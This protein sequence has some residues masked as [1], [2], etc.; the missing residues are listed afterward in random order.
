MP[1]EPGGDEAMIEERDIIVAMRDGTRLAVDVYRPDQPGKYPVLYAAALHNKDLQGPDIA[2]IL[3]PQP[4]HAPLWFG[5][6]EAGDT[7]RFIANGYVHVIAQPRGSAKSEGHYGHEDT[8]HYDLIEWITQQPWSNGKVGMVGISGY[9][10]E[11]WRAAAQ[12]HPALKAIFPYDACSAY[13]G[14]F[15]FRDFNPGGVLHTFPY[16]LDVFSTVHESRDRPAELPPPEEE[17]WRRAMQNPDFKQYINLYNILTQKGQR[18]FIMY[19]MMTHPWEFDGTVE[20]A[21]ETFKKIRIPFYTGSGAYAYTYKLHW[22]GAQHYFQNVNAPKKLLFTGP[23]HLERPF[24]QFHDEIIRWYD[25]WLKGQDAGIMNEPPVRY[26]LMGANEWRTGTDWPLPETQWTKYYL[27][28][29]ETL[30]TEPPRS[31]A[32]LGAAAREPDVFTQ[33]PVTR[34]TKV[35]RLRY[36]TDP[37]PHDVTVAGPI[38]LTLH[39]AIDQEDTNWIVVLKDVGPDVSV[40]TAREG[41]RDVPSS[42]PE[43]ELT[44]GWL[45]ASYRALDEKRSKPWDPFHKLTQDAIAPVKPSEVVEYQIQIIATANQFK[46]GHRICL[47]ITSMDVPTGTGAMTNVEYIP[48]H[49]CSSKTVTHRIYRDAERP[50][51]LLLPI[52]PEPHNQ[53]QA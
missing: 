42:L 31:A 23:A 39:A 33:M 41:E 44:R 22:L 27:S 51:H 25:H 29:W 3:P 7:R 46:A 35:E 17:L 12:G 43:R 30:S 53:R 20:R 5:P 52:I 24:H 34:T 47:D 37:L 19:L 6:I 4:A 9:A 48:Y 1:Q 32:E 40:R 50:S 2:D 16:L 18:T 11:Q 8:D 13:G 49:V 21:E 14:M 45:K 36:M 15:G 26:W 10:G 38:T 28:H